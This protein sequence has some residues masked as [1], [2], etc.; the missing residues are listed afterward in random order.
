MKFEN[1]KSHCKSVLFLKLNCIDI[2]I[3]KFVEMEF[4]YKVYK[5]NFEKDAIIAGKQECQ[6]LYYC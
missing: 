1:K 3:K 6:N 4:L 2:F 5:L